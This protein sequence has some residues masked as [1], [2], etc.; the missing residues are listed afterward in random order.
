MAAAEE[1]VEAG[2]DE[3]KVEAVG[4]EVV[5]DGNSKTTANPSPM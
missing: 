5:E 3:E 1:E 4:V 2:A